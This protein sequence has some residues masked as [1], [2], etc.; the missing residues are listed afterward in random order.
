M[1]PPDNAGAASGVA[2]GERF[3]RNVHAA[4]RP[5]G[6]WVIDVGIAA[7]SLFPHLLPERTLEAGG[8]RYQ[9][10]NT[11]LPPPEGWSKRRSSPAAS[12]A[13]RRR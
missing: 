2:A 3:V 10:Q 1:R 9:V 7:E 13:R 8:I 11:F 6:R 5:G 12:S 4:V